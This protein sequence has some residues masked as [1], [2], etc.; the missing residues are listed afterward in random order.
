MKLDYEW[1]LR[2]SLIWLIGL[3]T[4]ITFVM[5]GLLLFFVRAPQ[6]TAETHA[7][8]RAESDSLAQRTEV[9]LGALQSELELLSSMLFIAP[10][11]DLQ[12]V[13]DRAVSDAGFLAIYQVDRR[14]KVIRSAVS[15][16][17]G[18]PR[19]EEVLGNDMSRTAL[20]QQV[21]KD[22]RTIWGDKYLSPLS[23]SI[24]VS[25]AS[26]S[27]ET[28]IIG[29][30]PLEF[31]L[32]MVQAASAERNRA[33]WII[34][35]RGEILADSEN[36]ARIGV[37]SLAEQPIIALAQAGKRA[38]T[39]IEFEGR[40]YDAAIAYSEVLNWYFVTRSPSGIR[41]PRI[42][43]ALEFFAL[44]LA[45]AIILGL[46]LAPLWA[47]RMAR[48]ISRINRR[49]Q[50]LAVGDLP[51][52]WPRSR[53][54]ELNELSTS[55]EEMAN[56]IHER[57]AELEAIFDFSPAGMLVAAP[58]RGLVFIKANKAVEKLFGY[59]RAQLLGQNG[60]TLSLWKDITIREQLIADIERGNAGR[61]E[62]W[63][64][65]RDGSEF[66]A[67]IVARKIRLGEHW[68]IIWVAQD[69]TE[70]RRFEQ[71]IRELNSDLEERV[72]QRTELLRL[73]NNELSSTIERLQV[74]QDEL[75][76][77]EKLA[78]L[79]SLVA[80]VAHELNTP[81][82]NGVMA[83]S[84]L[85]SALRTFRE[86]SAE[87]IKRSLLEN[88]IEA[89][90]T[91]S[92]IAQRNL[93]RAA[94]L[95]SGFKQVAVDQTSSQRRDFMLDEMVGEIAITLRPMLRKSV[96]E[97]RLEIPAGIRLESYP[98]PLGQVLTNLIVNASTHGF[99]GRQSG[100][101]GV[102]AELL[103]GGQLR[104]WV[105]DDGTGIPPDLLP[106]IFDP[107]VTTK[108]GRGGTGL[109]LHIA[110]NIAAQVLGGSIAVHSKLGE[111]SCFE[112]LL[113][114]TAPVLRSTPE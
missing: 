98:G 91:G 101:I 75:V 43:A 110:H 103:D 22:R 114:L 55:L 86:K 66:L 14:G 47:T 73:T 29:E 113:P 5:A 62:A 93:Q 24:S 1:R 12:S 104:L 92:D 90:D 41:N 54:V 88:L 38:L 21:G 20:F 39:Q 45:A 17:L 27:G 7:E 49:A 102:G 10:E 84:T 68:R 77:A 96:A 100:L 16:A 30:V 57:E 8:L 105:K 15:R 25:V 99:S 19:Q 18:K 32:H 83:V 31:V 111:G 79:G 23:S 109:G 80:G 63:L 106:R 78:S 48:P 58:E 97:L 76:R 87:G 56:A 95:V 70:M 53:T 4:T 44:A 6:I 36:P 72:Q 50:R 52:S 2:T 69:V 13:L 60:K 64:I 108:M 46:L 67:R 34:D 107:F 89:V 40:R 3:T 11:A 65:R 74:A 33:L 28:I 26:P 37:V 61:T 94:E 81:I 71:E 59:S 82:G 85:R 51:E 35:Q 9:V 112:L 42:I